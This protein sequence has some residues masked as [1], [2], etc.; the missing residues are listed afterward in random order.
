MA[1]CLDQ[2]IHIIPPED[3]HSECDCAY[4]EEAIAR[5]QDKLTAGSG[6]KIEDNVISATGGGGGPE[7]QAGE[8]IVIQ[9]DTISAPDVATKEELSD[10]VST[11]ATKDE[12]EAVDYKADAAATAAASALAVA[13]NKQD[14]IAA[15]SHISIEN[16]VVSATYTKEDI[17]ALLGYTDQ[18]ITK[19]DA[20][21]NTVTMHVLG[22]IESSGASFPGATINVRSGIG[23]QVTNQVPS[24]E[25]NLTEG[26][27]YEVT[28][29]NMVSNDV[30]CGDVTA[31]A[32]ATKPGQ[33]TFL[34]LPMTSY[35]DTKL[36]RVE[37]NQTGE[38]NSYNFIFYGADTAAISYDEVIIEEV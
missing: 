10:A 32:A 22:Y 4:L 37:V 27:V 30:A 7:Y 26:T 20:A 24:K 5:K 3:P 34:N 8:N 25:I 38:N 19:T 2:G 15:G 33:I 1:E 6:I 23:V 29:K 11:L 17:L 31:S 18:T 16:N 14:P 36:S 35:P 13:N 12:V 9:N 28:F 21:G